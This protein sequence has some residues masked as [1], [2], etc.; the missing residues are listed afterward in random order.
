MFLKKDLSLQRIEN[1]LQNDFV[2]KKIFDFKALIEKEICADL[3]FA[4][5]NRKQHLIDLPY[6][7]SFDKKQIPTKAHPI[8]M[9]IELEQHCKKEIKDL[10]SKGLI[11]KSR[12][13]WSCAAF[14]VNK[15]S[16]IERGTPRLVINYK[17]LNKVLK[18]IRYPI[19]NK[20]DLRQKLH[21]AFVFSK[22]DMKS[23]FGQIQI[24]S[25]DYY[26]TAFTV[27][28]G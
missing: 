3:P 21:Y 9:N 7:S 10:E 15:N 28:F 20:K 16:E 23:G 27:P 11:V 2:K 12:S 19:P 14:Y 18:W 24:H 5:W 8:Q 1:Q 6:E 4:F 22:F 26:K 17:P 25:N 13:P